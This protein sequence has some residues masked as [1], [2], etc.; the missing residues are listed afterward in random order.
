MSGA[1]VTSDSDGIAAEGETWRALLKQTLDATAFGTWEAREQKRQDRRLQALSSI[2]V[3]ELDKRLRLTSDQRQRLEPII[4]RVIQSAR[5]KLDAFQSQP[6]AN[7]ELLLMLVN[8]VPAT[9]VA[10][11]IE[12]DQ[13]AGWEEL[14]ERY[15]GWWNQYQ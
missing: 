14:K 3:S 12:A 11:L 1:S 4:K 2:T 6:Y 5:A 10:A 8:G 13:L 9:E 7:T 15:G